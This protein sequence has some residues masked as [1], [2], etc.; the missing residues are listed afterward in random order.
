MSEE[1]A[2]RV[3][4]RGRSSIVRGAD[5]LPTARDSASQMSTSRPSARA[6][7][8]A[9]A[10]AGAGFRVDSEARIAAPPDGGT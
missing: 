9:P 8:R 3:V 1:G 7:P 5:H 4:T 2:E 10:A 6:G